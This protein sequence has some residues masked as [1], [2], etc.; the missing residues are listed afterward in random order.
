M[1]V[2]E[3]GSNDPCITSGVLTGF[4]ALARRLAANNHCRELFLMR[5]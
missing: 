1:K 3:G 5:K 2:L 4:P